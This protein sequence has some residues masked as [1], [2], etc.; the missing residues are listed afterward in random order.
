ML[1]AYHFKV[2]NT[3]QIRHTPILQPFFKQVVAIALLSFFFLPLSFW[4]V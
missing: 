4:Q 1:Q 3:L 2:L